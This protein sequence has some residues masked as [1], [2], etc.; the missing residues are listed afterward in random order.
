M[1]T[2]WLIIIGVLYNKYLRLVMTQE[3]ELSGN[4]T[5]Y[6]KSV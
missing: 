2:N 6:K 5:N 3:N 1:R 4:L